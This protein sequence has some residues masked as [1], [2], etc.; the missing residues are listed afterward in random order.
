M[1]FFQIGKTERFE[2]L[3]HLY[4]KYHLN[5]LVTAT[6]GPCLY[7]STRS[8][9]EIS[10]IRSIL[11]KA[12]YFKIRQL[13]LN[14]KNLKKLK[15]KKPGIQDPVEATIN[16]VK[17]VYSLISYPLSSEVAYIK[18]KEATFLG[19]EF[20]CLGPAKFV[21]RYLGEPCEVG[22][23]VG[24]TSN[25]EDVKVYHSSIEGKVV[26][27]QGTEPSR[28]WDNIFGLDDFNGRT[29]GQINDLNLKSFVSFRRY[30]YLQLWL[31]QFP[32]E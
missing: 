10:E 22:V 3:Q 17:T 5:H 21:E 2:E 16:K 12:R 28:G 27:P 24:F 1:F 11:G 20:D 32:H 14:S 25:G 29:V 9:E 31:E 4:E 7:H 26:S 13:R 6:S 18:V 23:Y 19:D 30:A 15:L 8:S